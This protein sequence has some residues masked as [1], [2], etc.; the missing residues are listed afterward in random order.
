MM[1][2]T[3]G[4]ADE[5]PVHQ[6]TI[7]YSFYMGKYEVTQ[8]QWQAV[9]GNNPSNFKNC[10]NCP[11]EEVSWNDAR[12][13]I[14]KLN[15]MND[16][17]TYRLPTEGEWEYACRA[18]TTG[19]YAGSLDETAWYYK[20][21]GNKTHAVGSKRPNDWGLADMHGNVWEWCEDWYHGTYYG[22]PTDGSAWLSGGEQWERVLRGGSWLRD[23]AS[24]RSANR[25]HDTPDPRLDGNVGFRVVATART[26]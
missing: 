5:K 20:N 23:A 15:Q 2:S 1:G 10:G 3:N 14:R 12:K 11:V 26:Q 7:N 4:E 21:S 8:A 19:D 6:V 25:G 17:Y 13:F 22:A 9:M 16:G 24:L 18:G